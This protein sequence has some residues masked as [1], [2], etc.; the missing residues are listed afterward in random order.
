MQST[1]RPMKMICDGKAGLFAYLFR[2][3]SILH[4]PVGVSGHSETYVHL[5]AEYSS[6]IPRNMFGQSAMSQSADCKILVGARPLTRS[7]EME[8]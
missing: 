2:T 1:Q 5:L 7:A 3:H 8:A 6:L 4:A